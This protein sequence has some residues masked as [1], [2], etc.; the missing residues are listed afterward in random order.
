MKIEESFIEVMGLQLHVARKIENS[1]RPLLLFNGIGANLEIL[2]PLMREMRGVE[3]I[4]FDMPGIG[5]SEAPSLPMRLSKYVR[6]SSQVL[7]HFGYG[8]VDVLGVSWGGGLA[9]EFAHRHPMRCK[10]LI[11]AATSAGSI[12]VPGKP[13]V[14]MKLTH[15]KRY[16]DNSYLKDIAHNIY[17][18]ELRR[19]PELMLEY[20]KRIRPPKSSKGYLFQLYA[21]SGW[22]SIH[23]LH[24][25]PQ[26]T[27]I[28]A[29]LD[30][31]LVPIVNAR[32]L[33]SRIPYSQL[34]EV[35][36]GHMLLLTKMEEMCR[37]SVD[38]LNLED[39]SEDADALH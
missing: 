23:W 22:T 1:K 24:K 32:I 12:M 18:G 39:L 25:L 10:K 6:L 21:A 19:D 31:P 26:Q 36:C 34:V 38:F 17:G 28:L 8:Q 15:P 5:L 16:F 11:L 9:Q 7:D 2:I 37:L 27:L 35:D 29:G 33:H 3:C 4:T 13:S 14:F 30:D 20:T